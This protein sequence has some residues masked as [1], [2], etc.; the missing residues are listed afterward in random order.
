MLYSDIANK[1]PFPCVVVSTDDEYVYLFLD[2]EH[3][4]WLANNNTVIELASAYHSEKIAT[5]LTRYNQHKW[6]HA[7]QRVEDYLDGRI[8][9]NL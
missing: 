5:R 8:R 6:K 3:R 4:I 9:V 2:E 1:G 7:L